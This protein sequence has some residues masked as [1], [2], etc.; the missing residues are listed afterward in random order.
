[1]IIVSVPGKVNLMGDHAIVHGYPSLLA[2]VNLRMVVTVEQT[3]KKAGGEALEI[4]TTEPDTYVRQIVGVV[5]KQIRMEKM[6]SLKITINSAIPA[7]YH[8]GSSAATAVGVTGA[9]VYFL[10][11]L[12]NPT[13]INEISYEAEKLQ[14]GMPSGGDN[15]TVTFGGLLWFRKELEF[16][17]SVWHL[18]FKPHSNIKQFYLIDTGRPKET[19]GEMV[20][21]V[22]EKVRR[23]KSKMQQTFSLNEVQVRAITVALKEGNERNLVNSLR[24]GEKTLEDMG[25]VSKLAMKIIR[26]IEENGGAAKILGGG[27][28]RAG[29]GFL[30]AYHPNPRELSRL[31]DRNGWKI[32]PIKLGEEGI[33]LE[34]MRQN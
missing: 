32:Q 12:W 13:R 28:R 25:V 20:S 27:G 11:Q 18:T 16:L 4:I 15:T 8:L 6:P 22:R 10:K 33:R 19:T 21:L 34:K 2:A 14:H 9:L 31:A 26:K 7:G 1:M 17:K 5:Q 23:Q 24:I 29:V 30:L 3:I